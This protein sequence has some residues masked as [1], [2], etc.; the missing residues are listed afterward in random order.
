MTELTKTQQSI[1]AALDIK[2]P[3]TVVG[4]QLE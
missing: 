3:S 4:I 1:F 2:E